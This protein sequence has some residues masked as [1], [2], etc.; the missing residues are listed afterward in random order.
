[1][2]SQDK[3]FH[4]DDVYIPIDIMQSGTQSRLEVNDSTVLD[5]DRSILI[6]GLAGQGKSILLRKLLSNNAKN[7]VDSLFSMS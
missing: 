5:N 7:I 2:I 4:V 3:S 6:K 1:M